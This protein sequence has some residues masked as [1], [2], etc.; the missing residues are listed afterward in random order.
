MPIDT[1]LWNLVQE[2]K[3]AVIAGLLRQYDPS[4]S[5]DHPIYTPEGEWSYDR[6][7]RWLV[8]T[9]VS[10][11]P[12]LQSGQLSIDGD[13]FRLMCNVPGIEGL[14]A[15]R[16][17]LG[18][19]KRAK[20]LMAEIGQVCFHLAP[21]PVAMH[22]AKA[23]STHTPASDPLWPFRRTKSAS[24]LIGERRRWELPR[25]SPMTRH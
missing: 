1:R 22:T 14:H 4:H 6:F 12:R 9:G 11:W 19:I 5:S 18:V 13:A 25:H 17:S 15:L 16:D 7:E 24:I 3:G 2:N 10:A 8:Q 21:Q 20:L 23:Y